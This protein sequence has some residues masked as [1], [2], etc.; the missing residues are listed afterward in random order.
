MHGHFD[1][2]MLIA[3][4]VVSQ[5]VNSARPDA[6]VVR[7]VKR[8]RRTAYATR[9]RSALARALDHAARAVEPPTGLRRPPRTRRPSSAFLRR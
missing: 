4:G 2:A 7:D 8:A 9:M 6:P 5:D 1:A 3:I